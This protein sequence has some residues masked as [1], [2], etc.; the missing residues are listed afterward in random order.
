MSTTIDRS[1]LRYRPKGN[2]KFGIRNSKIE[3]RKAKIGMRKSEFGMR[4]SE[5][6]FRIWGFSFPSIVGL[7]L[8][9]NFQALGQQQVDA[10]IQPRA[11]KAE[12][13][14]PPSA[15][16]FSPE[17]A[18]APSILPPA[19]PKAADVLATASTK[20]RADLD[21]AL[22]ELNTTREMISSEKLPLSKK[23]SLAEDD[24]ALA[25]KEL[26]LAQRARDMKNLDQSSLK[27]EI[28]QREEENT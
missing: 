27:A 18:P 7:V 6:G 28:K 24:L 1:N 23:L 20:A 4:N 25:R 11:P 14:A 22:K 8:L 12:F 13:V 16:P 17:T 2:S 21:A 3:M 19:P 15:Q 9:S 5:F 26:D 10:N